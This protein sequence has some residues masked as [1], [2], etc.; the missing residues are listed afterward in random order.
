MSVDMV[1]EPVTSLKETIRPSIT[2]DV[3]EATRIQH[4]EREIS[5]A[6][7][8][9]MQSVGDYSLS[10]PQKIGIGIGVPLGIIFLAV[11]TYLLTKRQLL[12]N[13]S[14][15][16]R[17]TSGNVNGD[18]AFAD[19]DTGRG[20]KW[21]FGRFNTADRAKLT[22]SH[23]DSPADPAGLEA[24]GTLSGKQGGHKI[25]D[26]NEER[27]SI[28][29]NTTERGIGEDSISGADHKRPRERQRPADLQPI[30]LPG[31]Q[32]RPFTAGSQAS[33][34]LFPR[35]SLNSPHIRQGHQ[36]SMSSKSSSTLGLTAFF[37][38]PHGHE[39]HGSASTRISQKSRKGST[40]TMMT[41][42]IDMELTTLS[43]NT[44]PQYPI[45]PRDHDASFVGGSFSGRLYRNSGYSCFDYE[46]DDTTPTKGQAYIPQQ[47]SSMFMPPALPSPS[48]TARS[49]HRHSRT[50]SSGINTAN[51]MN[52]VPCVFPSPRARPGTSPLAASAKG[53]TIRKE[54]IR[55]IN[56]ETTYFD[57]RDDDEEEEGDSVHTNLPQTH[58]GNRRSRRHSSGIKRISKGQSDEVDGEEVWTDSDDEPDSDEFAVAGGLGSRFGR[59][60]PDSP[61]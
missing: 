6:V 19:L 9:P 48:L 16:T 49:R 15:R 35:S 41:S 33:P 46:R 30:T 54:D 23:L 52:S 57:D 2:G 18:G 34:G 25:A 50:S 1:E 14:A 29:M 31:A 12:R 43:S 39:R 36:S 7:Q 3:Q 60:I 59:K 44:D 32:H 4:V 53:K 61:A 58:R 17:D 28:G 37:N 22:S 38:P 11:I 51:F 8:Y 13:R 24:W 20:P 5:P 40:A 56:H 55:I 45:T 26:G 27:H 21:L 10:T 42:N 47:Q